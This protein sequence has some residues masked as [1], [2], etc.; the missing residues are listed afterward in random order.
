MIAKGPG[1]ALLF[2]YR[3]KPG[4]GPAYDRAHEAVWPE[5]LALIDEAGIYDYQIWRHGDLVVSRMRTR[6][7]FDHASA[8]TS[9]S[10][11]QKRWTESLSHV[12]DEIA[13]AAG[14]PLWLE[15]I[16]RHRVLPEA[17]GS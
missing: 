15:E 9:A 14:E 8:T 3:L 7:G 13:D 1:E 11:V 2:I 10:A 12:F 6:H 17:G 5:I 16:F 4:M